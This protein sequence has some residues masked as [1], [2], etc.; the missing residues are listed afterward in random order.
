MAIFYNL[1]TVS[2]QDFLYIVRL[3]KHLYLDDEQPIRANK[4]VY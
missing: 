4:S 3:V 1:V 2:F